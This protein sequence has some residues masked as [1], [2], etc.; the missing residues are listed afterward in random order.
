[1]DSMRFWAAGRD[2]V[3]YMYEY[4]TSVRAKLHRAPLSVIF[5]RLAPASA[6]A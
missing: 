5:G 1:M 2:M 4:N 3:L 6:Y